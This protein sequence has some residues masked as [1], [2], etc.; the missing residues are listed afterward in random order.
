MNLKPKYKF[1]FLF[2]KDFKFIKKFSYFSLVLYF[3]ELFHLF[4]IIPINK[5]SSFDNEIV[6]LNNE[7][8]GK[9]NR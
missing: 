7:D 3:L 8:S 4:H 6:L 1:D 5:N 9:Q 2:L